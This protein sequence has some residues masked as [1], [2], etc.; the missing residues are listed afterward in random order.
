[1]ECDSQRLHTHGWDLHLM[2]THG[3]GHPPGGHI[4]DGIFNPAA[5][6]GMCPPGPQGWGGGTPHSTSE[7]PTPRSLFSLQETREYEVSI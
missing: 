7:C 2:T 1:M 3:M 5:V 4:W 6:H